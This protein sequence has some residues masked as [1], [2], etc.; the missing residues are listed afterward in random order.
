MEILKSPTAEQVSEL[1]RELA[2]LY[3]GSPEEL[4]I[5][6]QAGKEGSVYFVMQGRPEDDSRLVGYMG[7]HVKALTFL[8][9]QVGK[10]QGKIFTFRLLT[11]E[12]G[13]RP[14]YKPRDVLDYDPLPA[15]DI[16]RR[17]LDALGVKDFSVAVNS[18]DGPRR[19]LAFDFD[20]TI[21]DFARAHSLTI[22][23]AKEELFTIG[24][25]GTL[26]RAIGKQNGIRFQINLADKKAA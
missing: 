19:S 17:W 5:R 6:H 14:N 10:A 26:F 15:R 20:I 16:L 8:I 13:P 1:I 4:G 23:N 9:E 24:A 25:L 12:N 7:C 18:P 3:V 22:P 21:K 2:G 11:T